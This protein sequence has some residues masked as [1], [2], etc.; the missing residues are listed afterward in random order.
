MPI[1]GEVR[2]ARTLVI[3]T[4]GPEAGRVAGGTCAVCAKAFAPANCRKAEAAPIPAPRSIS[5]RFIF[6]S[7]CRAGFNPPPVE[8]RTRHGGLKPALHITVARE[9]AFERRSRFSGGDLAHL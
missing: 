6:G 5:R 9:G 2:I 8:K 4:F 3:F 1:C 7:P